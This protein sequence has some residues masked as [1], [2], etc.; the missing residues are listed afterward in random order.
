MKSKKRGSCP[1]YSYIYILKQL[2]SNRAGLRI[3]GNSEM[4]EMDMLGDAHSEIH[5]GGPGIC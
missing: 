5:G 4:L 1:L 3:T 2:L